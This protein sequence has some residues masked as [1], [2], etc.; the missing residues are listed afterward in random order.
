MKLGLKIEFCLPGVPPISED[1]FQFWP[2]LFLSAQ[3]INFTKWFVE[4]NKSQ[5]IQHCG[6]A[7]SVSSDDKVGV[8]FLKINFSKLITRREKIFPPNLLKRYHLNLWEESQYH[9][10]SPPRTCNYTSYR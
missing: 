5:R 1:E 4:Q 9:S 10:V 8:I 7:C 3:F 6:F 2:L